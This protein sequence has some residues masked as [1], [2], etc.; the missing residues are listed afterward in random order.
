MNSRY[1]TDVNQ[2][3]LKDLMGGEMHGDKEKSCQE[4]SRKKTR[5]EKKVTSN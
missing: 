3:T 2:S 4:T 1:K 5:E